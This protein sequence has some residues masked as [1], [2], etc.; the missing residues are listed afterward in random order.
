MTDKQPSIGGIDRGL[1]LDFNI[2]GPC[3]A[4][5]GVAPVAFQGA[6]GVPILEP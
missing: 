2:L 1:V 3:S 6:D 4:A 5:N